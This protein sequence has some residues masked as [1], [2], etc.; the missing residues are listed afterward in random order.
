MIGMLLF[1][2]PKLLAVFLVWTTVR[3]FQCAHRRGKVKAYQYWQLG[4]AGYYSAFVLTWGWL[5]VIVWVLYS[6]CIL[7][8]L[9]SM[10]HS[11]SKDKRE[12]KAR[13]AA[14]DET[15]KRWLR[16]VTSTSAEFETILADL[17]ADAERRLLTV[18]QKT[19]EVS[20]ANHYK[21]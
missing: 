12:H 6:L 21:S 14:L 3:Q 10:A 11:V 15:G 8:Y 4:M 19:V 7:G 13:I 18:E 5:Q 20:H 9:V 16:G 17:R 2:L 1:L